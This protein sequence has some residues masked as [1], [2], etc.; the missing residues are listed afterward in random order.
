VRCWQLLLSHC[1]RAGGTDCGRDAA[2]AS[3]SAVVVFLRRQKG[4]VS[5]QVSTSF[6]NIATALGHHQ[7]WLLASWMDRIVDF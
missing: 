4:S 1:G 2:G 3:I 7:R 6:G 5:G